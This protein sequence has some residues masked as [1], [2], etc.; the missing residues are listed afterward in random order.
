M[1]NHLR[2]LNNSDDAW[3]RCAKIHL[4]EVVVLMNVK[5]NP[6]EG[7]ACFSFAKS[8]TPHSEFKIVNCRGMTSAFV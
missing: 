1:V 3:D 8:F 2:V 6:S 4:D 7:D 5:K